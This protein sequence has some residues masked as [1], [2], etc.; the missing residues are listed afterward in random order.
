MAE[1]GAIDL[2]HVTQ[3]LTG[4]HRQQIDEL[5]QL[6]L[7]KNALGVTQFFGRLRAQNVDAGFFTKSL[8]HFLYEQVVANVKGEP[9]L[10]LNNK[11]ARFLLRTL[12]TLPPSGNMPYLNL[13]LSLLDMFAATKK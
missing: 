3:V 8:Y 5:I 2:T 10:V 13:E 1:S 6:I 7:H 12:M 9:N 4:S 11:Q